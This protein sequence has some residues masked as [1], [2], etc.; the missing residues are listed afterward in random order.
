MAR[1]LH[2]QFGVASGTPRFVNK[3]YSRYYAESDNRKKAKMK[4]DTA[5]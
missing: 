1:I 5:D 4:G 3:T 2:V